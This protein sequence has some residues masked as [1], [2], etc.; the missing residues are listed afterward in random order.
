MLRT[1]NTTLMAFLLAIALC[2]I[3]VLFLPVSLHNRLLLTVVF[4]APIWLGIAVWV[5]QKN[6][7]KRVLVYQ[8][9][10]LLALSGLIMV[11]LYY[12]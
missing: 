10:T 1:L 11:G 7:M 3:M 2:M 5:T 12:G 4:V 6:N 8:L 9:I